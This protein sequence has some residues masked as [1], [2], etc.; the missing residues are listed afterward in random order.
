MRRLYIPKNRS[1]KKRPLSIPAMKDRAYQALFKM[2]L[3]PVAETLADPNS[4]GFRYHRRCADAIAQCFNALAKRYAPIW[5]LEADIKSCFDEISHEW[6]IENIP[7]DKLILQ[8]WLKA[9]Y[10]E[11]GKIYPTKRGTPQGGI[12]SPVLANMVLDGLEAAARNA[13]PYRKNGITSKINVIRYADDFIITATSRE[14]LEEKVS[15]AVEAFLQE[16]GLSL[17]EEKT[18]ITRIDKGFDFLGQNIRKYDG[19]LL[20]K[21]ARENVIS[22]IRNI[23][24]TIHKYRGG[25]TVGLIKELNS[26]I[27]GWAYYHRH[28]VSARTFGY[29][30]NYIFN[31]LWQWMKRRHRN[32]SKTW[33]KR[34]YWYFGSK[35]WTFSTVE[36]F[37]K[38]RKTICRR[39]E[40][41]KVCSID[42]ARHIKIRGVANPFDPAYKEYFFKRRYVKTYGQRPSLEY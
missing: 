31:T 27:R 21:P 15:P 24:D 32:K 41:V 23:R 29:V 40:L 34:K 26:K 22:F 6:M 10:M 8:K 2:A 39:Y 35:P 19:K 1:N 30:D 18:R 33:M 12:A 7:M 20:I 36:K 14:M 3:D 38:G 37:K 28:V 25:K 11:D 9:G 4:Y 16:R 5:I 17:S 13:V 42:I